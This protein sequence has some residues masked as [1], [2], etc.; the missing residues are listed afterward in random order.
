MTADNDHLRQTIEAIADYTR[1]TFVEFMEKHPALG[2]QLASA[3]TDRHG[4]LLSQ[5]AAKALEG[6]G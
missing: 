2:R 3:D 1:L 4:A 6:Q 5:F